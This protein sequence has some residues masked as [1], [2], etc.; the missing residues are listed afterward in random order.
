[1]SAKHPAQVFQDDS[2]AGRFEG[3]G[4]AGLTAPYP[5]GVCPCTARSKFAVATFLNIGAGGGTPPGR[6]VRGC[7]RCD[8]RYPPDKFYV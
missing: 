7:E 6:G 4:A 1:M 5:A 3:T 2:R 8:H